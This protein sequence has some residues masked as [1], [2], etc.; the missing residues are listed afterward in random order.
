MATEHPRTSAFERGET[1]TGE[2]RYAITGNLEYSNREQF[3]Q[4][5][6]DELARGDRAFVVDF[7]HCP[8]ID[9]AGLGCLVSLSKKIRAAGGSLVLENLN[10]DLTVLFE[11][12]KMD[13]MFQIRTTPAAKS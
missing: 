4:R 3:R 7:A 6:L 1:G 9:S 13:V 11:L 8:Y 5:I 10:D 12:T 2:T